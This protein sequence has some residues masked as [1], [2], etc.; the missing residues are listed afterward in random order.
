MKLLFLGAS[1]AFAVLRGNFQSNMVI[2]SESG[3]KLLIDCGTDIRHSL[4]AQNLTHSDI[5]AVY[6]SHLHADHTGGL[7]WFGFT[8]YFLGKRRPALYISGDQRRKLWFNL[9]SAGMSSLENEL[10]TLRT[11]FNIMPIRKNQ[12]RWENYHFQLIRTPHTISNG[13]C[14]PSYGLMISTRQTKIF[15]TT[16]TRFDLH[17]LKDAYHQADIIFHDCETLSRVLSK[18]HAHYNELKTLDAAIKKKIWLYDYNEEK[19]PDAL[20]DGFLGF[21]QCGQSFEFF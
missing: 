11:Y 6:I 10:A 16:D 9:L 17:A 21:V 2:I 13:Q 8:S 19:L 1:S 18:Q 3:R 7:E 5:D 20:N 12:F 4:Y 15:L 14:L